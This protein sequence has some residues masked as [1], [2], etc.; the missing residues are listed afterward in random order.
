MGDSN[1]MTK[2]CPYCGKQLNTRSK[3]CP[4]CG[5][6]KPERRSA[7]GEVAVDQ[8]PTARAAAASA[9][10]AERLQRNFERASVAGARPARVDSQPRTVSIGK[11]NGSAKAVP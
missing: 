10:E 11:P 6:A 9:A 5:K 1:V 8:L 2:F 7:S 4:Q 3:I